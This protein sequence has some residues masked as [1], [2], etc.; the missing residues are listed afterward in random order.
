[1]PPSQS[2]TSSPHRARTASTF[3]LWHYTLAAGLVWTALMAASLGWSR[4]E[5]RRGILDSARHYAQIS[6]QKEILFRFRADDHGVSAP[7][8]N[9]VTPNPSLARAEERALVSEPMLRQMLERS[10]E[11][12]G[13]RSHLASLKPTWPEN[14]A[15]PWEAEALKAL[16][17]GNTEVA[18]VATMDGEEYVRVMRP[19]VTEASCLHC[20]GVQDYKIGEIHGGMSVSVPLAALST[21]EQPESAALVMVD[22]IIWGLG[23]GV[24]GFGARRAKA[25]NA[26]R[27]AAETLLQ[28]SEEQFRTLTAA[29]QNAIL[30]MDE[31]GRVQFWNAAAERM[32]GH[33]AGEV[34]NR[35]LQDLIVP[36]RFLPAHLATFPQWQQTGE[37]PA[38][39]K[40]LELAA[41]RKDGTEF[42][43]ELSLSSM[44]PGG[45]RMAVAIIRDMTERKRAEA[46]HAALLRISDAAQEAADLPAAFRRIHEIVGELLSAQNFYVALH[47]APTDLL[48]FPYFVDEVDP[49]PAPRHPG[50]GLTGMVLRTGQPLL[51]T[52]EK[53][54]AMHRAGQISLVG[55]PPKDWLGVP[56][57]THN[58]SIGVLA[59]QIYSGSVHYTAG[60]LELL[61][62]VS[63]QIATAIER[64]QAE[65][66]LHKSET[67]FRSL[68]DNAPVGYHEIDSTGRI[69]RVNRTEL[70]LLGYTEAEMMGHPIAE[71]AA[72]PAASAAVVQAKLSGKMPPGIAFER[73][74]RRKDGS[75]LEVINN[76]KLILDAA[77][78]IMGIRSSMQDNTGAK[79]AAE[80]V[81]KLS[82]AVEQS[83]ASIVITDLAGNIEYT[84]PR[85]T[86]VTGYS[87]VEAQGQ[88]PRILKS[89]ELPR[90]VY[91]KLWDTITAGDTWRGEFHNKKKNGELF[92]EEASIS[93][94]RNA[95][96]R[97]T[98]YLAVKMDITARK[99]TEREL[100]AAKAAAES[101]AQAKSE[102][103]ATMSHEIRT[104]MN[105]VIGMTGLL[106]DTQL[107]REQRQF[108][109]SVRNSGENLMTVINDILDFSKI[110]A[111]KL[112]FEV[113]DFDL[114]ETIE[115]TL[116]ML[117]ERAQGKGIELLDG[118]AP[119]VTTRLRGDPGRLR[120]VITNLL[121]NAIKFT[122]HG[123]V[124][125]RVQRESETSTHVVLRFNVVDT[126]IGIPPEVQG[127]LFQSFTQADS[128]TT[129]KYGGTGLGLAISK[130]LVSMMHGQIGVVSEP[131]QGATFW[132]TAQFEKQ[133]GAP[134]PE[135]I[136][137]KNL[138]NLRVLVV[139][140][141]A[142]NRQILRHQIFAW[143]MQKGSAASGYEAL[144]ILRAAAAAG[145]PY[146]LALL[147]MQM[148]EM[149]GMTLAKAIKADPA[150][151]QT[152]LI[153]LT[154]LGH[155]FEAE[156]LRAAG[157]EAYLIKP[158]KQS[159]LLD[160]LADVMG[161]GLLADPA[162]AALAPQKESLPLLRHHLLVAEDNQVNQKIAVAQ[163]KKLGC[164]VDVVSNGLEVLEA[165]PR[166]K[167][168]LVFMD[169][170][171]PEMDGYEATRAIRKREEDRQHPCRWRAP[172]HIIAMTANAMQGDREKCLAA[173]MD[174]YVTKPI[175]LTELQAAIERAGRPE[176]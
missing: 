4:F 170:Q 86:E 97:T 5:Q 20:H 79:R 28:E 80:Q 70:Q 138:F 175:R 54:E 171:M 142:T 14:M 114:V 99:Q 29:A 41:V 128:S 59:V 95:D 94:I 33:A 83:P 65:Q 88:N 73:Q 103:L 152:H 23:L 156:E 124:V 22:G 173:G 137:A 2:L 91:K 93:P 96:G 163:L 81:R 66:T 107:T 74:V 78:R 159:R 153:M 30:T 10:P 131:G 90:E 143:K 174:D 172:V 49:V 121:G 98:H 46:M 105:G 148:P 141:N 112:T 140:D 127:R 43:I 16:A 101:A 165:L 160:C 85:F 38:I 21:A 155:R 118:I 17:N 40:T 119:E 50:N 64:K 57:I 122:D 150:I 144:K 24:I 87:A 44:Q 26:E 109:E 135:K 32:F 76:D 129:R 164:T 45:R 18:S 132:F 6:F 27:A 56:L 34:L 115:G 176:L 9:K 48:S 75:L 19:L 161:N 12:A 167:Y 84:N 68:F 55:T 82:T 42:P 169:C 77:G 3:K 13:Y 102:F 116:D 120:Q 8:T 62:Y 63:R 61:L 151:A 51:L 117:A 136:A 111:G 106:L 158:V 39:G 11:P 134:K 104:P 130:Q 58:Q 162:E 147:D 92:W 31:Q 37:G 60:D 69:V 110:E 133:T 145:E 36:A 25:R 53:I 154:S 149:D 139:D 1:M 126:G 100:R 123:E 15:D 89:G 52:A 146:D 71:F 108:A 35:N 157:L 47:D 125:L 67:R 168:D 113:L 7:A 72:D 166:G